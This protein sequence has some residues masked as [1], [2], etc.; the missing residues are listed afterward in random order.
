MSYLEN[1]QQACVKQPSQMDTL[2]NSLDE[3]VS[4]Y[5][6]SLNSIRS[7]RLTVQGERPTK[8]SEPDSIKKSIPEP[9]ELGILY[10]FHSLVDRLTQLNND[11]ELEARL[12]YDYL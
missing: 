8:P 10:R 7:S 2:L 3:Q 11:I 5:Y 12:L 6:N 9:F 1:V 4:R